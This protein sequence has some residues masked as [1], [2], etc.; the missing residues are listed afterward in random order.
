[1]SWAS[2]GF[3]SENSWMGENPLMGS[4]KIILGNLQVLSSFYLMC[5]HFIL[6]CRHTYMYIR[7]VTMISVSWGTE[8]WHVCRNYSMRKRCAQFSARVKAFSNPDYFPSLCWET[9]NYSS[10]IHAGKL[11]S[12][13]I[14][15]WCLHFCFIIMTAKTA[16]HCLHE[17]KYKPRLD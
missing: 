12:K 5:I 1:M 10:V 2:D 9:N 15:G 4:Q 17:A 7:I 6:S 11:F 13:I 14:L 8:F 16:F 3:A